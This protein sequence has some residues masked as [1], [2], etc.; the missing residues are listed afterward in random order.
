MSEH[1]THEAMEG[2][3]P[4]CGENHCLLDEWTWNEKGYATANRE[5]CSACGWI[6]SIFGFDIEEVE[7][8]E[9]ESEDIQ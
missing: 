5:R 2:T 8:T 4:N 1:I 9:L 6:N 3:C 7:I